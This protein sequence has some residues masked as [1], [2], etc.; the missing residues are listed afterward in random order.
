MTFGKA[1]ALY[2]VANSETR[3][4]LSV[5]GIVSLLPTD[6]GVQNVTQ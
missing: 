3:G 1:V 5:E 4:L 2:R 6:S